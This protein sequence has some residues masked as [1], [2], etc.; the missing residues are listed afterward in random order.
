MILKELSE[1][2]AVSGKEDPVRKLILPAIEAHVTD[3]RI[4]A[5]GSVTALQ[6]GSGDS[7][8]RVMICAHMDE[9]GFMLTGIDADGLLRFSAVGGIDD[10]ILPG[11]RVKVGDNQI[12]GCIIW[13]PIH[14][15]RDQTVVKIN[16]LRIDIGATSKDNAAGQ[17]K[18]GDRVGFATT[19][20]EIG[21]KTLRGKAFDD[22]VG[23]SLL[24]DVL[25]AGPYPVDVLAAFTT[26]EEIGLRGAQVAAQF[27]NPD[28]AIVLEGTTANDLPDPLADPDDAFP[29]NPTARMGGGP[30]LTAMDRSLVVNPKVLAL[31]RQAAEASGI[32]YQFKTYLGGG[33]DGGAI[34]TAFG[35]H[36]TAV[37]SM[38]CRY[39]HSPTAYLN[40]DDYDNVLRLVRATLHAL[41]RE[42]LAD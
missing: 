30:V 4:D 41:T 15:N 17:V 13:V 2:I 14:R 34:H 37:I 3:I 25:Q 38:P 5:L 23:C 28:L 40:R 10:R 21:A 32:P 1:A 36:K 39:I 9:V 7:G 24:V 8:L 12:P 18:P 42:A 20:M 35:G 6:K 26:Q 29:V 22:R 33:T 31:I 16:A 11:L 19:F 27:L